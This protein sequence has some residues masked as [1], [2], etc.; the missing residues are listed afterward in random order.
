ML[1]ISRQAPGVARRMPTRRPK[2]APL[3][4]LERSL[5]IGLLRARE[6]VMARFRPLLHRNGVTEQQWRV[7]RVLAERSRC[8]ATELAGAS[9]IHPASLSRILRDLQDAG[10]LAATPSPTD[11]RR[12]VVK[13][14]PAGRRR[15]RAIGAESEAI[16][17]RI[18]EEVGAMQLAETLATVKRLAERLAPPPVNGRHRPPEP[19][20][21]TGR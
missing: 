13:L 2:P 8:D 7:I 9:C 19:R 1:S 4:P 18:E 12:L 15:F 10:V 16:Y 17:R 14:T 20:T 5:S 3:R 21:G 11:S 6:S